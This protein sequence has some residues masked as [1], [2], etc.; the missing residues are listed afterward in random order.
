[1]LDFTLAI[2]ELLVGQPLIDM[3]ARHILNDGVNAICTFEVAGC[4]LSSFPLMT[5]WTLT[6]VSE[7]YTRQPFQLGSTLRAGNTQI[8]DRKTS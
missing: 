4:R 8:V 5:L 3:D 7:Y 1:M 2:I 6:V